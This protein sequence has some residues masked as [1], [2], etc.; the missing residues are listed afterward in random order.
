MRR[1]RNYHAPKPPNEP[2]IQP[3]EERT[4]IE[5]FATDGPAMQVHEHA[6]QTAETQEVD[7][8]IL[9]VPRPRLGDR[10]VDGVR[11][12]TVPPDSCQDPPHLGDPAPCDATIVQTADAQIDHHGVVDI[13]ERVDQLA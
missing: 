7:E 6:P 9:E 11:P 3:A 10:E 5:Q 12:T 13:A 4:P 8:Q 2:G 1:T